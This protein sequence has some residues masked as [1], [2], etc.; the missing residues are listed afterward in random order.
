MQCE[1]AR[2]VI[3]PIGGSMPYQLR[4]GFR[5]FIDELGVRKTPPKSVLLCYIASQM[6]KQQA[7]IDDHASIPAKRSS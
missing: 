5:T 3:A 7:Q 4:L 6:R 2:S 1:I